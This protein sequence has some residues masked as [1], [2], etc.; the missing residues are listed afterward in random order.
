[1]HEDPTPSSNCALSALASGKSFYV[2]YDLR[3]FDSKI[4]VAITAR[5]RKDARLLLY[6][7]LGWS[8]EKLPSGASL[9]DGRHLVVVRC[10]QPVRFFETSTA[11][12][13]CFSPG[14]NGK[15]DVPSFLRQF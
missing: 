10:P 12:L 6:D 8:D 13:T 11:R 2:R 15:P 5:S 7:S 9:D 14:P 4:A 1:V 3:G